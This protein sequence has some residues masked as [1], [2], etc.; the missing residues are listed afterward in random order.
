MVWYI[1]SKLY[2]AITHPRAA[3]GGFCRY[4]LVVWRYYAK[5]L[6]ELTLF[7]L[8]HLMSIAV[9]GKPEITIVLVGRS[10]L[11]HGDLRSRLEATLSWNLRYIDGEVIHVEWN[12]FPDQSSDAG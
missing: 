3:A 1:K 10:D 8:W 11:Y 5:W 2:R 9:C 4:D 6:L 12:R 7:Q